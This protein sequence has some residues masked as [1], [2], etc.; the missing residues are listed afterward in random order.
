MFLSQKCDYR[1]VPSLNLKRNFH[2]FIN[3]SLKIDDFFRFFWTFFPFFKPTNLPDSFLQSLTTHDQW[4]I[5]QNKWQNNLSLDFPFPKQ[6]IS[7]TRR[8]NKL[9]A[10]TFHFHNIIYVASDKIEANKKCLSSVYM[11]NCVLNIIVTLT[12]YGL[13]FRQFLFFFSIIYGF[14]MKV[15]LKL[16]FFSL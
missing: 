11:I 5:P 14:A 2:N 8:L 10:V 12:M 4:I 6:T 16:H 3:F 13:A 9:P 1:L 7:Q 15:K